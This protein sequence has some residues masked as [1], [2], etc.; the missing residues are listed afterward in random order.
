[1]PGGDSIGESLTAC[2][3]ATVVAG[4]DDMENTSAAWRGRA[5]YLA[6]NPCATSG[7]CCLVGVEADDGDSYKSIFVDAANRFAF[8]TSFD[9]GRVPVASCAESNSLA[10]FISIGLQ[11]LDGLALRG[12]P[13]G[14]E[15]IA[16]RS[17]DP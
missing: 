2:I 7:D 4:V 8:S 1:M 12:G 16:A 11:F 5:P 6:L 15:C 9:F 10:V 14:A 3:S 17:L 13:V